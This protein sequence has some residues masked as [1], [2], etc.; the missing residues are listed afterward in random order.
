MGEVKPQLFW[1]KTIFISYFFLYSFP[2]ETTSNRIW[3]CNEQ[4]I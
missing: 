3:N 2:V 1:S 4:E